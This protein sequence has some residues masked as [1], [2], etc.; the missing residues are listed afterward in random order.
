MAAIFVSGV[1]QAVNDNDEIKIVLSVFTQ[2]ESLRWCGFCCRVSK[3]E[4]GM[5]F[6]SRK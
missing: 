6:A 4:I 1:K 5:L 2:S 3:L